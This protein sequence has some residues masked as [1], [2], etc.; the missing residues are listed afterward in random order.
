MAI[1]RGT[2]SGQS[3]VIN[4]IYTWMLSCGMICLPGELNGVTAAA[5]RPGD[6]LK[7]EKRLNQ[8]EI[9]GSNV[10][11]LAMKLVDPVTSTGRGQS[12]GR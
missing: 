12:L 9:L 7:Q 8:A 11:S 2:G 5:D 6:I 4:Q 3:L 10:L 1:G